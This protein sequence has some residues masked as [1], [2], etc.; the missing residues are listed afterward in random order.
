M[1]NRRAKKAFFAG[2]ASDG[3]VLLGGGT[4]IASILG[5]LETDIGKPS[6]ALLKHP[7]IAASVDRAWVVSAL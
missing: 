6:S 4:P 5:V 1:S 3:L 7:G 2:P